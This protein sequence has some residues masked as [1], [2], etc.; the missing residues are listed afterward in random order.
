MGDWRYFLLE[1]IYFKEMTSTQ[2]WLIEQVRNAKNLALP[3]CVFT[4]KQTL[5][6]GSRGNEW[7]SVESAILFSFAFKREDLP[8][9]LPLQ[10]LSIY[11][12]SLM[13]E[14]LNQRGFEVWVKWPNDLYCAS[15]KIGGVI[16]QS[17]GEVCVC[18]IGINLVS[19][20]FDCLGVEFSLKQKEQF[21]KDFLQN[22]FTYPTWQKI[23]SNYKIKFD[24]NY[25]FSFH[26]GDEILFFRDALL[27]EDGAIMVNGQ[28]IYSLR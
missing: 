13:E 17:I 28:K 16:T 15:S 20:S 25:P 4:Q 5:G 21:I 11:V 1:L 7:E 14:F 9:D 27:C 24:K 26:Y 6:V 2:N 10:S 19:S 18:G 23:F 22:F 3:L 12:G 8:S